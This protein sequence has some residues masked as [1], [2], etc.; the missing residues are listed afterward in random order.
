MTFPLVIAVRL[1]EL[2]NA[3]H[4][5]SLAHDVRR[6]DDGPPVLNQV[7]CITGLDLRPC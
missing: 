2:W 1:S 7:L 5:Q 6:L 4:A 3:V